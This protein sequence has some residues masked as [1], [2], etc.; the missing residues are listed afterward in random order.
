MKER[1]NKTKEWIREHKK[2]SVGIV[3]AILLLFG[4][5]GIGIVGV[6]YVNTDT[7]ADRKV[8]TE[9]I[10]NDTDKKTA[11]ASDK[12]KDKNATDKG[13]T[14]DDAEKTDETTTDTQ[15][16]DAVEDVSSSGN[17][18]NANRG[19]GSSSTSGSSRESSHSHSYNTPIYGTEQEWVVDQAAW[20][21]TVNEPIYEMQERSICNVCGADI[22]GNTASHA[23]EHALAG[24][25][26]GHHSEW[27]QV[28]TGTNTY[29]ID[30][31][32]Q[33]HWESYSVVTGYQCS[34]GA[35]K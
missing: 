18:D 16:T 13:T 3:I 26:G 25:G 32:E 28:Q 20:T 4:A 21:E 33:G 15:Q 29:T 12:K 22:T 35:T 2:R 5:A 24:E 8:S 11:K 7:A 27:I 34:C 31:P 1:F 23:K 9:T 6:N 19:T 17:T 10:K 30:H 14:N